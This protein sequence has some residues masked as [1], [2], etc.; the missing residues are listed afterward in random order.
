V[1]ALIAAALALGAVAG[2]LWNLRARASA[3]AGTPVAASPR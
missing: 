3:R 1:P 2:G